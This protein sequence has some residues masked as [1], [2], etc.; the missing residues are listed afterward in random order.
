MNNLLGLK[1]ILNHLTKEELKSLLKFLEY[2][3]DSGDSQKSVQLVKM[4]IDES[5]FT[6]TDIQNSLYGKKNYMAFNK[7]CNRIKNKIFEILLFDSN[8]SKRYYSKRNQ[9]V[10]ELKKK[11]IQADILQLKGLRDDLL[12]IYNQII[13]RSKKNELYDVLVQALYSKQRL[14]GIHG[15]NELV[16]VLKNEIEFS[17]KCWHAM[18]HSQSLYIAIT[19]KISVSSNF[20]SYLEDLEAAISQLKEYFEVSGSSIIGYY[21]FTLKADQQQNIK[22]FGG[23]QKNLEEAKSILDI[24]TAAYTENRYGSI[25]INLAN[26]NIYLHQF[27]E[28]IKYGEESK[29]Y[30]RSLPL[31]LQIVDEIIFYANFYLDNLFECEQIL[32]KQRTVSS[33]QNTS[34]QISKFNFLEAYLLF[35]KEKFDKSISLLDE[36]KEIEQDK[37]GWNINR[38][39]LIILN[40]I[41]LRDHDS[42]DLQIQN[43]ERYLRRI[44]KT[45]VVS[46]RYIV[47]LKI[48]IKLVNEDFNFTKVYFSR[49]KYFA[50]LSSGD[51][52]FSWKIRSP[53]LIPFEKWFELNMLGKSIRINSGEKVKR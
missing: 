10:F 14:I 12:P 8:L 2:Y 38:R 32:E 1:R 24:N 22:N 39:I 43:L 34:L 5:D 42:V 45:K 49:K 21:F 28:S 35:K 37:E 44:S 36:Y 17:E 20:K 27:K 18:N 11:L 26:N 30:F 13:Q 41:E 3:A 4:L 7:L 46:E 52:R 51:D 50:L 19:N 15:K 23:A 40:R 6:S 25:L 47:I 33:S 31:T 29:G 53:E 48:L 9:I 16:K